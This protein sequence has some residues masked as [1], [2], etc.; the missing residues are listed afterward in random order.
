[1]TSLKARSE[2][3]AAARTDLLGHRSRPITTHCSAAE[4]FKRLEAASRG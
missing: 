2:Q 4:L 3:H 1:M